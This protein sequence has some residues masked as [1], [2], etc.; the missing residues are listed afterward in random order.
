MDIIHRLETLL[1]WGGT[2]RD[3]AFLGISGVF[4][5]VSFFGLHPF[6]FDAAWIAIVLC[7]LP[8]ILEAIIGLVTDFDIKA[9][10][11]VSLALVASVIIGEDFAAGEVAF[12][13]QIGALL[14]DLTV[15]KARAGIEKLVRLTPRRPVS[16]GDR[17]KA[18]SPR[19]RWP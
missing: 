7:G 6:P 12:I 9:D 13:M 14:E 16:C 4:L 17:L 11:L 15:A 10:V 19:N 1:A 3:I 8:I 2:R 5:A 18:S